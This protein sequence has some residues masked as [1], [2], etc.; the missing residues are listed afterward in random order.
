M[1]K[2]SI[3]DVPEHLER[4]VLRP[5]VENFSYNFMYQNKLENFTIKMVEYNKETQSGKADV[6]F[7]MAKSKYM[8]I[9]LKINV[10]K[11]IVNGKT[12]ITVDDPVIEK[13]DNNPPTKPK[14]F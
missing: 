3:S 6:Y 11:K 10:H 8:H 13:I 4:M 1:S 7:L 2:E 5:L 14:R 12:K 9:I